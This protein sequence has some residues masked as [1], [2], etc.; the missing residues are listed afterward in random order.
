LATLAAPTEPPAPLRFSTTTGCLSISDSGGDMARAG[1]STPP[2]G[3]KGTTM[4]T[5]LSG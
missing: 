3:G 5:G 4:R 1:M 2:P